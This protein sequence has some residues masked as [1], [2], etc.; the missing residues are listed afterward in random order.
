[1]LSCFTP[2]INHNPPPLC[3]SNLSDR[4]LSVAERINNAAEAVSK[5]EE[6]SMILHQTG[7]VPMGEA[8]TIKDISTAIIKTNKTDLK[9]GTVKA[10]SKWSLNP[11]LANVPMFNKYKD[12]SPNEYLKLMKRSSTLV[13]ED[14]AAAGTLTAALDDTSTYVTN[15]KNELIKTDPDASSSGYKL[16]HAI[17]SS[18]DCGRGIY[19]T[20]RIS[21]F[22]TKSFFLNATTVEEIIAASNVMLAEFNLLP[23]DCKERADK[24][25]DVK[26]LLSKM[27]ITIEEEV[28]EYNKKINKCEA[29]DLPLMFT[30]DELAMMLAADIV[31]AS[32]NSSGTIN[33]AKGGPRICLNCGDTSHLVTDKVCTKKCPQCNSKICPGLRGG[34]CVV[35]AD[36]MPEN[37]DVK[38]AGGVKPIPEHIY[39]WLV[40][41]RK[42]ERNKLNL[43]K[44]TANIATMTGNHASIG[45]S[46]F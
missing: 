11:L 19:R 43:D 32:I 14:A 1:M 2:M 8:T 24:N 28:K 22:N 4:N 38:N 25:A 34:I 42:K 18:E 29:R 3:V 21:Q 37:K 9:P 35:Y 46:M 15:F 41:L 20:S 17:L 39:Q 12:H 27:P 23:P 40:E 45:F 6:E 44:P 16:Y 7:Q 36:E 26:M 13:A 30:Y 33:A 31:A 10:W 5:D